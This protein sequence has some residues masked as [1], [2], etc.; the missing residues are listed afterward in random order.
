MFKVAITVAIFLAVAAAL[1]TSPVGIPITT[2]VTQWAKLTQ[3]Q[4]S[5]PTDS[6]ALGAA[7]FNY[8][9]VSGLLTFEIIHDVSDPTAGH[10]H[11]PA[12]IGSDG[13]PIIT[14]AS[15]NS[16]IIGN[17]SI[18][19]AV[20]GYL[21]SGQLYVNIHSTEF[22]GG[23]I[24]GQI[25]NVGQQVVDFIETDV[26]TAI[27]HA[28]VTYSSSAGTLKYNVTHDVV[29]AT[30]AHFHGPAD[31]ENTANPVLFLCNNT[32]QCTSPIIGTQAVSA[33]EA[34]WFSSELNYINIHSEAYPGGELRGQVYSPTVTYALPLDGQQ[35]GVNTTNYGIAIVSVSNNGSTIDVFMMST[36]DDAAIDG[37]HVH[38]PAAYGSTANPVVILIDDTPSENPY[39]PAN[40]TIVAWMAQGL[41]YLNVH[42]DDYPNGEVRGQFT[43]IGTGYGGTSTSTSSTSASTSTSAAVSSTGSTS[44]HKSS[45]STV[46]ASSVVVAIF[47]AVA[48]F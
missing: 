21:T 10:I 44:S 42:S 34:T 11:G 48:L 26:S 40:T 47:S 30:A 29:N 16:P 23:E 15:P 24:R 25:L 3:G 33:A 14:F 5:T 45:A 7:I 43:P 13:S 36:I 32:A 2:P 39:A 9:S 20:A 6:D 31:D 35:A 17:A 8:N 18:T 27:G 41:A 4:I 37:F 22:S 1:N 28:M 46:A 12:Y 19:A 38:A